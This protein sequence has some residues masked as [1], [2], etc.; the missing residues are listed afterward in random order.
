MDEKAR[1]QYC[2]IQNVHTEKCKRY[3]TR[4]SEV[5][6]DLRTNRAWR[7]LACKFEMG[8]RASDCTMAVSVFLPFVLPLYS[9]ASPHVS[10]S[11]STFFSS[12]LRH[13]AQPASFG[14]LTL[15]LLFSRNDLSPC[16]LCF[17]LRTPY[18]AVSLMCLLTHRRSHANKRRSTDHNNSVS[19][20]PGRRLTHRHVQAEFLHCTISLIFS[21]PRFSFVNPYSYCLLHYSTIP[22]LHYSTTPPLYHFTTPPL[23]YS[24]TSLF[25]YSVISMIQ[26]SLSTISEALF[27]W[28][29]SNETIPI[30][31]TPVVPVLHH[32]PI[33]KYFNISLFST[34]ESLPCNQ[35]KVD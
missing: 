19:T 7:R 21:Y 18:E 12:V 33:P 15:S 27:P 35:S 13:G 24:T 25:H 2:T 11:A 16:N 29:Y 1:R 9:C 14:S 23:Y 17:H 4:D 5:I 32:T 31:P 28:T 8:L 10:G 34:A 3:G 30:F 22:L 20:L 6:P 26:Y